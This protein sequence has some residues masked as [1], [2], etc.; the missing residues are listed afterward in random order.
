MAVGHVFIAE[1][2]GMWVKVGV[3]GGI[4]GRNKEGI[5]IF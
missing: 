1:F 5:F 3:F 2:D 4:F